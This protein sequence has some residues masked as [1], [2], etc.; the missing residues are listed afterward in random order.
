[1]M[2]FKDSYVAYLLMYLCYFLSLALFSGLISIYL[3]DKGYTASQV[4]FVVSCSF[5]LSMLFQPIIGYLNDH[6][7]MKKVNC[8]CLFLSALLGIGFV[9]MNNIYTIALFYSFALALFNGTNPVIERMAIFS[10]FT[11]GHIRIWGTIGY[12]I[13]SQIG[14]LIYQYISPESMY[15]CFSISLL[16]CVLG[17]YGTRDIKAYVEEKLQKRV[18]FKDVFFD[19]QFIMYLVVASLFYGITNINSTYL[20]AMF[21]NEGIA[22]N[23]VSTIIFFITLSELPIIFFSHKY[24]DQLTNK[25]LLVGI[26]CLL[27]IQFFTYSFIHM[28]VIKIIIAIMTKAV[29]TMTFIMLN[30]K[31]V[32]SLVDE[33][34]QMTA[35]AVVSTFKSLASILFQSVGGFILDYSSYQILFIFLFISSMITLL[36]CCFMKLPKGNDK[37]LFH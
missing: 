33:S 25:Q 29:A 32:A 8:L 35:L 18:S 19:R 3:M 31:I 5:V 21:Q 23:I 27:M 6:Y 1:M 34:H 36:I 4:S 26:L 17:I 14:G 20:P 30:M 11:Y 12:A 22:V 2:K 10:P 16:I 9:W 24:M 15:F 28:K 37:R 7:D 13:G